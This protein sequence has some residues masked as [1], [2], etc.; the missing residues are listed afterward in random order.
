MTLSARQARRER[1]RED[2]IRATRQ[3]LKDNGHTKESLTAGVNA[4]ATY[5]EHL[6]DEIR[7]CVRVFHRL[8]KEA[9]DLE[10]TDPKNSWGPEGVEHKRKA[11]R[12]VIRG[13][14]KALLIYEDSYNKDDKHALAKIEKEFLSEGRE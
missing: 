6:E 14:C 5:R 10:T 7:K 3:G 4:G 1:N 2:F 12:G 13:L 11:A 9:L 8:T